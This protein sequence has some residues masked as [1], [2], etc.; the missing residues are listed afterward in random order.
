MDMK[1]T[2]RIISHTPLLFVLILIACIGSVTTLSHA[3]PSSATPLPFDGFRGFIWGVSP[4]DISHYEKAVFYKKEGTREYYVEKDAAKPR[5]FLALIRYD[6]QNGKLWRGQLSYPDFHKENPQDALDFV[7]DEKRAL[8][9]I[10]GPSTRDDLNWLKKRYKNF[11]DL[12]GQAFYAG[13]FRITSEWET[14][15]TLIRL[16]A[17]VD[18]DG[19]YKI[20][21]TAEQISSPP[22]SPSPRES[23][24][25]KP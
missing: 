17:Y 16:H 15:K 5:E 1:K 12:W 13:D 11:P 20:S 8:S 6:F 19:H 21:Y 2:P 18:D 24:R 14:P 10:Y 7:M 23:V 3:A 22:S 25:P 9:A 4:D